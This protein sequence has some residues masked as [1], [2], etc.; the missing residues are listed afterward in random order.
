VLITPDLLADASIFTAIALLLA[1]LSV[2][3]PQERRRGLPAMALLALLALGGLWALGMFGVRV[4]SGT[5]YEIVREALLALLAVAVIRAIVLFLG[6]VLLGGFRIPAIVNEVLM[7]LA[8]IGYAIY[9][10]DAVG[11]NLAGIVTT[12]A[13]VTGA[14]ALSAADTLGNLSAGLALQV[15]NTL[16]IGDW[17]RLVDKVARVTAIRWRSMA[18][19]TPD[20]ETIVVPN[21]V[22]M[23][24]RIVVLG[25]A[26]ESDAY[27]RRTVDFHVDFGESPAKVVRIVEDAL[28]CA[29]I[30]NVARDPPPFCVC[31]AF[32]ENGIRYSAVYFPI[33]VGAM[34]TS[35][36][37]VLARVYA[38]LQRA[39][40]R[41]P[42]P[43]RVLQ[44]KRRSAA[45]ALAR[46]EAA[47]RSMLDRLELFSVLVDEERA[48][49]ARQLHRL[50]YVAGERIF[51]KGESADSLYILAEGSVRIVDMETGGQETELA[52][53]AAPGYFG[54]MGLLTGQ[55]RGATVIAA[56]DVLCYRLDK[57]G[58]DAIL[59]GRPQIVEALSSLLAQR[60]AQNVVRVAQHDASAGPDHGRHAADFV[61]LIREFFAL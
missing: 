56:S 25:R 32:D 2:F 52:E 16:R 24:D 28:R 20:N 19:A 12:S 57:G 10:L 58:F 40:M 33:D 51:A 45:Q 18:F 44:L 1:I 54:E 48:A 59:R 47:C 21:S 53:L 43:Q 41:I 23:K 39:G 37:D 27:Y 34:M 7:S 8:L 15:E 36:S 31:R 38:T 49:V 42:L 4:G 5:F 17:V 11:V 61:R 30:A 14:I 29:R 50:P 55:P 6:R 22:L 13:I 35:D 9:R 26:G 60:Q 3:A 46:E